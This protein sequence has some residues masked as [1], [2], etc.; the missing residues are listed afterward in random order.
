VHFL[1]VSRGFFVTWVFHL[2]ITFPRNMSF[3]LHIR[4]DR[5]R[6][7]KPFFLEFLSPT[8]LVR[9]PPWGRELATAVANEAGKPDLAKGRSKA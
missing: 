9:R 4:K 1:R 2:L 6:A 5:K 3:R 7:K 8:W